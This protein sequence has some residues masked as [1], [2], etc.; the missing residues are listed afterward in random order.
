MASKVIG[1]VSPDPSTLS[2]ILSSMNE[3]ESNSC[4][5]VYILI[6]YLL[7]LS[8]FI[9]SSIL[10]LITAEYFSPTSNF[11]FPFVDFIYLEAIWFFQIPLKR[12]HKMQIMP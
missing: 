3:I 5:Y 4:S 12:I 6:K 11:H 10:F 2:S 9:L 1:S 7:L 8:F